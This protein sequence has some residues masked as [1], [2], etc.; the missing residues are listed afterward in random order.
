MTVHGKLLLIFINRNEATMKLHAGKVVLK[1]FVHE[2]THVNG[3]WKSGAWK[4]A[5]GLRITHTAIKT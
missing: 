3:K 5:D 1:S 2:I 4:N